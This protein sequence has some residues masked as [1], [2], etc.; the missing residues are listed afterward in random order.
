MKLLQYLRHYT[1]QKFGKDLLTTLILFLN[2]CTWKTFFHDIN[3]LHQYIKFTMEEK[4]NGELPFI[5]T[6]LKRDN[7]KIS[8]LVYIKPTQTDQYIQ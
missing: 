7:G 3:N 6:L 8:T 4:C 1:L 5:D 2:V